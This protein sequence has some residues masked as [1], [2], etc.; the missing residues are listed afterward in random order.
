MGVKYTIVADTREELLFGADCGYDLS[1]SALERCGY[2]KGGL[3]AS[4]W[5]T[6]AGVSVVVKTEDPTP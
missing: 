2:A 3:F 4:A 1:L 6:K 5:R